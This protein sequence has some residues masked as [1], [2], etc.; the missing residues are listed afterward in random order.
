MSYHRRVIHPISVGRNRLSHQGG[1]SSPSVWKYND[2]VSELALCM[3]A[4][5]RWNHCKIGIDVTGEVNTDPS[6]PRGPDRVRPT[7]SLPDT[8]RALRRPDSR[9]STQ[10][11]YRLIA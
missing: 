10:P 4:A 7:G 9:S 8:Q 6:A 3:A 2:S 11:D 5:G 1:F